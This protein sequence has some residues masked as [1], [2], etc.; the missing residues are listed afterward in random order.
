M[1]HMEKTPLLPEQETKLPFLTATDS[2][3]KLKCLNPS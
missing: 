2:F 3:V 1:M